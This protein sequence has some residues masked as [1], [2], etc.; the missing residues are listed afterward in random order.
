MIIHPSFILAGSFGPTTC[1]VV[2]DIT[3]VMLGD[4]IM[5]DSVTYRIHAIKEVDNRDHAFLKEG[6]HIEAK[7][8]KI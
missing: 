1:R 6:V 8:K 4:T 3:P 5:R 2:I 7:G